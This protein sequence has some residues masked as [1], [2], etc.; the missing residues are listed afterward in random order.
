MKN[1][2]IRLVVLSFL[3][4]GSYGIGSVKANE[5]LTVSNTI[6]IDLSKLMVRFNIKVLGIARIN[7]Q[8]EQLDGVM[9]S[10][11][12]GD[13]DHVSMRINVSSINTDDESRDNLLRGPLFFEAER[14]PHITF[15]GKCGTHANNGQMN[16]VGTLQL[17]GHKKQIV[18]VIEP[19]DEN[20]NTSYRARTRI[21]RSDFG[22]NSFRHIV[23]DEIE[24]IVTM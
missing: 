5:A 20:S 2:L 23:S 10:S 7:G 14:Y 8:F 4:F 19:I 3:F 1:T 17:H 24:I 16:L 12:N 15:E 13:P 18:F 11:A 21:K 22:L 9:M 6:S